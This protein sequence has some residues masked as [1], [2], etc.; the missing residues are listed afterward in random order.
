[1][2]CVE[3]LATQDYRMAVQS[4]QIVLHM[5]Q[6][7]FICDWITKTVPISTRNKIQFIADH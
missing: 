4:L 2:P 5:I 3:G 7:G 1:M 6:A